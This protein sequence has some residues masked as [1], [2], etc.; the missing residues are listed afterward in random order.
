MVVTTSNDESESFRSLHDVDPQLALEAF[1]AE[2]AGNFHMMSL[3]NDENNVLLR[4]KSRE[5]RIGEEYFDLGEMAGAAKIRR[6]SREV[7]LGEEF[8]DDAEVE[9]AKSVASLLR[10][11][12]RVKVGEEF[13]DAIEVNGVESVKRGGFR[14]CF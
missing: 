1:F 10:G 6:K 5:V 13:Y 12:R 14:P 11:F 9:G 4:P 8:F 2:V 7:R 3:E